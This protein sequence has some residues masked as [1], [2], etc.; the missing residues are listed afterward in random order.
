MRVF[1]FVYKEVHACMSTW[2]CISVNECLSACVSVCACV[3]NYSY[4]CGY[5]RMHVNICMRIYEHAYYQNIQSRFLHHGGFRIYALPQV[6]QNPY[7]TRDHQNK[8]HTRLKS[9]EKVSEVVVYYV[10][11]EVS[12]AVAVAFLKHRVFV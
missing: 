5:V 7:R 9:E 11:S 3:D 4:V 12:S 2:V 1:L 6:A 8:R 10:T